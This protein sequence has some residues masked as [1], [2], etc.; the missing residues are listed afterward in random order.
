MLC[1]T[2]ALFTVDFFPLFVFMVPLRPSLLVPFR[3][4][5]NTLEL[6]M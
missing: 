2:S 6:K 4:V 3:S 1:S 5:D